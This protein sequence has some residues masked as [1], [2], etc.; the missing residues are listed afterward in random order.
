MYAIE[1][2]ALTRSFGNVEA[3]KGLD[4]AVAP[5]ECLGLLGHNGAGKTTTIKLLLG[6]LRPT[7]G[8]AQVLGRPAGCEAVRR[9]VGYSPKAHRL[10]SVLMTME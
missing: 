3:L 7:A 2:A 9:K 1:T 4:L 8:R 6:L 10:P 5:G